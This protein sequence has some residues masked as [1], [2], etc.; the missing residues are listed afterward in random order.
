MMTAKMKS[1]QNGSMLLLRVLLLMK[2]PHSTL[3]LPR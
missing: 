1:A 2:L 3:P